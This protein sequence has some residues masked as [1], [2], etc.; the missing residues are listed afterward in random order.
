MAIPAMTINN[1]DYFRNGSID[2]SKVEDSFEFGS[3]TDIDGFRERNGCFLF[4]EKKHVNALYSDAP[5][6][7]GQYIALSRLASEDRHTVIVFFEDDAGEVKGYRFL[8]RPGYE[9]HHV[10]T[11]TEFVA[12]LGEWDA[13]ATAQPRYARPPVGGLWLPAHMAKWKAA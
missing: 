13:W 7:L 5:L 6:P 1:M 3:L 9:G 11:S 10:C 2:F 4:L 12:L 8:G